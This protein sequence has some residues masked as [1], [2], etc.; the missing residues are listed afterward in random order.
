MRW[1]LLCDRGLNKKKFNLHYS[2]VVFC[3]AIHLQL[4]LT[5]QRKRALAELDKQDN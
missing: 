4:Q 1:N 3:F 5:Q 2:D